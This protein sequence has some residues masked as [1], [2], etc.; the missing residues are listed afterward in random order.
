M[1]NIIEIEGSRVL[2]NAGAPWKT[3]FSHQVTSW[4]RSKWSSLV[5]KF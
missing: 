5:E 1:H 3:G 4:G 2:A